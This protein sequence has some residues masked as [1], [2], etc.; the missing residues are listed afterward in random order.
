[1][2]HYFTVPTNGRR[3]SPVC[4]AGLVVVAVVD[5]GDEREKRVKDQDEDSFDSAW[6]L[7]FLYFRSCT[8]MID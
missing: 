4:V 7:F 2:I 6:F 8:L 1:M 3:R 5:D